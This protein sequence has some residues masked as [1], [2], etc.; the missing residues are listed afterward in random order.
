MPAHQA[1]IEIMWR[2]MWCPRFALRA[3]IAQN[4]VRFVHQR[5]RTSFWA[6]P[7]RSDARIHRVNLL[8]PVIDVFPARQ[9]PPMSASSTGVFSLASAN[10]CQRPGTSFLSD[11]R[12]WLQIGYMDDDL[13]LCERKKEAPQVFAG[14]WFREAEGT[15]FE[16]ATPCGAPHFQ[17]GR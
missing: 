1:T 12:E 6:M 14:L 4:A 15:R 8:T 2:R 5:P 7:T 16:L 9:R 17:C 3:R 11:F 13:L 10:V